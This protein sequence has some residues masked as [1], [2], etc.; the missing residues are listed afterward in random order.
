M[1]LVRNIFIMALSAIFVCCANNSTKKTASETEKSGTNSA[2]AEEASSTPIDVKSFGLVGNVKKVTVMVSEL[3]SGK[4]LAPWE[5]HTQSLEFDESGRVVKDLFD[6]LYQ[7]DE[8]GNFIKGVSEKSKMR[9][10]EKG[11]I[12]FYENWR[13]NEDDQGYTI[14]IEYDGSDRM[15]KVAMQGWEATVDRIYTY[16]DDHVYPDRANWEAS[17]E[18]DHYSTVMDYTYKKFDS[19]GNWTER[20]VHTVAKHT[21][22]DSPDAEIDDNIT[23]ERREIVYY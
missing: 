8:K 20:E 7:Y 1:K 15:A 13:D 9:R 21:N 3:E 5:D 16:S 23:I 10:D 2:V 17:D 14:N 6:N 11:R 4:E 18:G 22:V 12:V 19:L